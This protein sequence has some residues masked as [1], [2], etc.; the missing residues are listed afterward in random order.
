M[1]FTPGHQIDQPLVVFDTAHNA[2]QPT[3]G[4]KGGSSGCMASLTLAFGY[5]NHLLQEVLQV[6]PQLFFGDSAILGQ[7]RIAHQV[8]VKAGHHG[9]TVSG[10]VVEV[11]IQLKTGIHS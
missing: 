7:R 8:V 5:R 3:N 10:A 11:R 2:P 6:V 1:I 4:D 9:A